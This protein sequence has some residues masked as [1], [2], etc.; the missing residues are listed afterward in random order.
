MVTTN[1][2]KLWLDEAST[3]YARKDM[4]G[5]GGKITAKGLETIYVYNAEL[6][7]GERTIVVFENEEAIKDFTS[8]EALGAWLDIQ[9]VART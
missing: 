3:G 2:T 6:S 4:I 8:L 9:K 1:G 5:Q 7:D